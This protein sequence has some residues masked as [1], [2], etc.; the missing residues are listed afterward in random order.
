[1]KGAFT[2]I[3][4]VFVIVILGILAAVAIP[5]LT[6]TRDDAKKTAL[7]SNTNI[8]VNDVIASYKGKGEVPDL[9]KFPACVTAKNN[10]VSIE[11]DGDFVKVSGS[12]LDALD[13]NHRMKGQSIVY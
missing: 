9:S 6:A 5:K 13:G 2:M 8:C 4:L 12:G 1:M 7:I 3:E 10:G 11:I